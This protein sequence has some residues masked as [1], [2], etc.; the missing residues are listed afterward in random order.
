MTSTT[1]PAPRPLDLSDLTHAELDELQDNLTDGLRAANKLAHFLVTSTAYRGDD[2]T[3]DTRQSV[4]TMAREIADLI[5]DTMGAQTWLDYRT[6][7]PFYN[8]GHPFHG[9]RDLT[10][11][12]FDR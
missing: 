12:M 8:T 5:N 1:T 7:N 4:L 11:G 6:R 3:N 9:A 2:Q 10:A